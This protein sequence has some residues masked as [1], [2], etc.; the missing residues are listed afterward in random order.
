MEYPVLT[1]RPADRAAILDHLLALDAG[2]RFQRF[3]QQACDEVIARYVAELD[4]RRDAHFGIR[5]DDRLVGCTHLA[6]RAEAGYAE[7]G[8]SVAAEYRR[9]GLAGRMLTHAVLH[10]RNRHLREVVMYFL[11]HN[12]G[13]VEL[14][15]RLGMALNVGQ[16]GGIARLT[17][18]APN[19]ESLTQEWLANLA[20]TGVRRAVSEPGVQP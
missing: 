16:G 15:K 1:L 18:P 6:I 9:Q 3:N 10:A 14:A 4:F 12:V 8:V 13:L 2:D 19:V 17:Q 11:P 7:V 20:A 5:V